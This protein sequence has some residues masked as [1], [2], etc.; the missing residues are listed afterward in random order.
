MVLQVATVGEPVLAFPSPSV[1]DVCC[2]PDDLVG[3]DSLRHG[4]NG[5]RAAAASVTTFAEVIV[6]GTLERGSDDVVR[7]DG[8]GCECAVTLSDAERRQGRKRPG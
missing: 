4:R 2:C 1:A 3:V 6:V 5:R 7:D 8:S